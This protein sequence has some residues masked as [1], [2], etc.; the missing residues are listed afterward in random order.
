[1]DKILTAIQPYISVIKD[2][3][4]IISLTV[5]GVVAIKGLQT[6]R[7]QL[8]GTANYELAKRVLKA[9]Y[10]L[11]DALQYVRNPL[12]LA[13]EFSHAVKEAQLEVSPSDEDY[14]AKSTAAVYQL[15]WKPVFEAY[16]D[17]ELEAVEAET[18]WGQEARDA[19]N[20]IRKSINS[21]ST[22]LD[23]YLRD[24]QPHGPRILDNLTRDTYEKIVYS[25]SNNP[26]EDPYLNELNLSIRAI[27]EIARPYLTR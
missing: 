12:I 27:E 14:H 20:S 9:T 11:R 24:M 3:I 18:L 8:K 25:F 19:T 23:F 5:A 13:G 1:M 6:W 17:L 10:R 7:D 21:L 2:L 16:K 26:E 4:T 15:R 22:A